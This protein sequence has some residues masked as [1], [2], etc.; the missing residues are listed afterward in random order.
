MRTCELLGRRVDIPVA[1]EPT[2]GAEVDIKHMGTHP[3]EEVT[4]MADHD[5]AAVVVGE[6]LFKPRDGFDV[7]VVGRFV[8][9]QQVRAR[10]DRLGQQ[11]THTQRIVDLAHQLAVQIGL[12]PEVGQHLGG[13]GFL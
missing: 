11:H 9:Q 4:V 3:V 12:H 5:D 6:E 1:D 8:E 10:E 2:D 13:V 7:E